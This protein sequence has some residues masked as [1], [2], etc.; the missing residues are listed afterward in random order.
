MNPSL[1]RGLVLFFLLI[2]AGVIA[3]VILIRHARSW[4]SRMIVFRVLALVWIAIN[5]VMLLLVIL[6]K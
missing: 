6:L 4:E 2:T 1:V 3:S 5:L